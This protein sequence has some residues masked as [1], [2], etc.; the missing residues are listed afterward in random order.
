MALQQRNARLAALANHVV[1]S[2]PVSTTE[3]EAMSK[4]TFYFSIAVMVLVDIAQTRYQKKLDKER[5]HEV[6]HG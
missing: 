1:A 3:V 2:S 6:A 4:T 5:A